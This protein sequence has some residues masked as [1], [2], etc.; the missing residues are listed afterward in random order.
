MTTSKD[1]NQAGKSKAR[2][3]PAKPTSTKPKSKVPIMAIAFI[4]IAAVLVIAVVFSG[5][6]SLGS[7]YGDPTVTGESLPFFQE[8]ANDQAIGLP[9]PEV[10]GADFDGNTV[11]ITN[12]GRAKAIA[13]IAHWCSHCQAEVPRVTNWLADGGGVDGVD[14]YSVATSMNSARE[15]FPSSEW[16]EREEWPLPVIADDEEGTAHLSYG[17]GG[18]PFW[19]F[20]DAAGNVV[21]R[22]A[23]EL[24]IATLESLMQLAA[25]SGA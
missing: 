18:F 1:R 4:G 21:A 10:E 25:G 17:G 19:V 13:F 20:V 8:S 22:T 5:G 7:E 14:M 23:G 12:D 9:A 3:G 24:E 6:T 15:N 16:L 2:S 11:T